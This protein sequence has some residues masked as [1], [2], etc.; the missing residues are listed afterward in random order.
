M[1]ENREQ[2]QPG[3]PQGPPPKRMHGI[4]WVVIFVGIAVMISLV[5]TQFQSAQKMST[6]RLKEFG[7][8]PMF[9]FTNEQG[10]TVTR[11]DLDGKVWVCNFVFTRCPGPCPMMTSR[12]LELQQA[13]KGAKDDRVRLITVT[14]DPEY[15]TPEILKEY[16]EG[17][18]ADPERWSFLTGEYDKIEEFV[19]GGMLQPLA[20]EPDGLPAHSTRFVIVDPDG[21]IRSFRDGEHPEAVANLL[22]D[23]GALMREFPARVANPEESH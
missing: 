9:S 7:S 10:E 3:E 23:I 14:V 5:W 12:M 11:R 20:E 16:A 6:Q 4:G 15:D 13:L 18:R 1:E 17:T 2:Q 21:K 19:V 22:T 8:V